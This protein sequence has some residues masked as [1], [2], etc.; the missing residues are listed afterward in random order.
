M[1]SQGL[2][3]SGN[4]PMEVKSANIGMPY[5]L[6][7]SSDRSARRLRRQRKPTPSVWK[8]SLK[9]RRVQ[10][11]SS[12]IS[13]GSHV[14]KSQR[15]KLG[16]NL[17]PVTPETFAIWKK[18]RMDK[19]EAETDA[20]R[21][22]KET[23]HAAGKNSG[24]SG[25]DLVRCNGTIRGHPLLTRENYSSNTIQNGLKTT[26][27]KPKTGIYQYI[28]G[29]K[30]TRKILQGLKTTFKTLGYIMMMEMAIL[31]G[32]YRMACRISYCV[33]CF[34]KSYAFTLVT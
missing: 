7:L 23:Q 16:S 34:R 33:L 4:A 2:G 27:K 21:K 24:M 15:H 14:A 32:Q 26:T 1:F 25:R 20:L 19:K 12:A 22:A 8:T 17:T 13:Q 31:E 5:L 10:R 28:V 6:G 3:G 9:F 11:R 29:S 18:T 30:A